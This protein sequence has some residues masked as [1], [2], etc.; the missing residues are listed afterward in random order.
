MRPYAEFYT[1]QLRLDANEMGK[2]AVDLRSLTLSS[3]SQFRY[4]KQE[5]SLLE[6]LHTQSSEIM[7]LLFEEDTHVYLCVDQASVVEVERIFQAA[8]VRKV[9]QFLHAMQ[10]HAQ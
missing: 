1:T 3:V 6:T 8:A 2:S 4:A 10:M 7:N 9:R 5:R